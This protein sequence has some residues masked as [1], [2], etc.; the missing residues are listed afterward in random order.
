MF[1]FILFDTASKRQY[2]YL[3]DHICEPNIVKYSE[4]Q[5]RLICQPIQNAELSKIALNIKI[6]LHIYLTT[7]EQGL[8]RIEVGEFRQHNIVV[9][10]E[11]L[12]E[13]GGGYCEIY[14]RLLISTQT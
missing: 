4:K 13:R 10:G 9:H 11:V 6:A 1:F 12:V 7:I 14:P 3:K 8:I 2:M 5:L